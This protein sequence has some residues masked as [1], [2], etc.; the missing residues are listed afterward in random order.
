MRT[1]IL[2]DWGLKTGK[3]GDWET[4]VLGYWETG[5]WETGGLGDWR[6]ATED[7]VSVSCRQDTLLECTELFCR[8]GKRHFFL[9]KPGF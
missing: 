1:G 7:L 3:L 5:D 9:S 6:L 4:S 2:G 8:P